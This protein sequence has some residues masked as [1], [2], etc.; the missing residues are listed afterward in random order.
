MYPNVPAFGQNC[1]HL[2]RCE[3]DEQCDPNTGSCSG[4]CH[5]HWIGEACQYSKYTHLGNP[6][7]LKSIC[8]Y[9]I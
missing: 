1:E 4:H 8:M 9:C 3:G 7:A 5:M 6:H 2:C